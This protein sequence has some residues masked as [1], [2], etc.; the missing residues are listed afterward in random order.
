M[1]SI[2]RFFG[3]IIYIYTEPRERHNRPHFHARYQEYEAVFAIN[4]FELLAGKVPTR[5]LKM[6]KEWALIHNTELKEAWSRA[7][8]GRIPGKIDP[9]F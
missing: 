4:E 8:D 2:S 1:P 6:I 5:Q 9:N 3:V 7:Q